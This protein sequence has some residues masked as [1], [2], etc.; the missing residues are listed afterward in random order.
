MRKQVT[1]AA[2]I[3]GP[4]SL[5]PSTFLLSSRN[6]MRRSKLLV[7]VELFSHSTNLHLPY[8]STWV[9]MLEKC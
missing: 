7:M 5:F 2:P 3:R 4:G 6:F 9:N 1:M 8:W